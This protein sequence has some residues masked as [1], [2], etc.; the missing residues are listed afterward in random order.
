[1]NSFSESNIIVATEGAQ[2]EIIA[3]QKHRINEKVAQITADVTK[4]DKQKLQIIRL[5]SQLLSDNP[6]GWEKISPEAG[7][8]D[9]ISGIIPRLMQDFFKSELHSFGV[10]IYHP[11]TL[12]E[13][14]QDPRVLAG[15]YAFKKE[16]FRPVMEGDLFSHFYVEKHGPTQ[17]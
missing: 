7:A 6:E 12:D 5:A 1:M 15:W 17:L 13:L 10:S 4:A 9:L 2:A 8:Y 3:T 14:D 11:K 16:S